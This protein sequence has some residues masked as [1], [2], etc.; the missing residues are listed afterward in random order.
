MPTG[1]KI[2]TTLNILF[3][4]IFI[5]NLL[6]L[7]QASQGAPLLAF[8]NLVGAGAFVLITLVILLRLARLVAF[9][10]VLA[11]ALILV[12][13]LQVLL[14]LKYLMSGYGAVIIV[15]D[16][17]VIFYVIGMRGYLASPQAATYFQYK[18]A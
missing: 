5:A 10:R 9:A 16:L 17:V 8:V 15:I 2:I 7:Q 4:G 13:G 3:T 6:Y 11:Y 12:L 14:T 1:F 18:S